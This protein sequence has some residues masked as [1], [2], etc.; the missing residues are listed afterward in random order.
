MIQNNTLEIDLG[1]G[2]IQGIVANIVDAN[3]LEA[4]SYVG[5]TATP[6]EFRVG[7][8]YTI[9][10]PYKSVVTSVS[11]E[12][13]LSTDNYTS[14][15]NPDFD[16]GEYYRVM[17]AANSFTGTV[18]DEFEFG[19]DGDLLAGQVKLQDDSADFISEGI[20][21]GDVIYVPEQ[22]DYYGEILAVTAT[23]IITALHGD[24]SHTNHFHDGWGYT[25]FHDYV[26]SRD[27]I[28]HAKFRGTQA[29]NAVS[30]ERVRDVCMGYN[31]DCSA[32]AAAVNFSGNGGSPLITLRDYEEDET[33][34]VGRAT[35]TP[36][37]ASSGSIRVSNINYSLFEN[38]GEI[39]QWFLKNK[40]HQL[41]Y[42]AHSA[43]DSPNGGA[44]CTVGTN[45]L[46]LTGG[47]TPSNNKRALVISA[48]EPLATQ[49]RTSG[50]ISD[51]YE[52][53]NNDAGDDNF[54]T[55]GITAT[56][57]DQIRVLDTSP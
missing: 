31:A 51:Y 27:H 9:F 2:R 21:I 44:V 52:N 50:S 22:G 10:Q 12:T 18:D 37:V 47:G 54:Q 45:C 25:I 46:T 53:E 39:P 36:T 35:F 17:P 15:T 41:T 19:E 1:V 16:S 4:V 20:T 28:F 11:S 23:T 48:G 32:T 38:N 57:N 5:E 13:Q 56:F 14:A 43:G 3:T 33:T 55:G 30:E 42:V 6:I 34:E 24:G 8:S 7:D 49:N 29:T 26:F 40:W